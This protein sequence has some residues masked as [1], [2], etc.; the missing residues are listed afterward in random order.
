MT[1]GDLKLNKKILLLCNIHNE[2]R[3]DNEKRIV[4]SEYKFYFFVI[5]F[6]S[7]VTFPSFQ[8]VFDSLCVI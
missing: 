8:Y 4:M 5:I 2:E 1:L 6:L 7:C 3:Y